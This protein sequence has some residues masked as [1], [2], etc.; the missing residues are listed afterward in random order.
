M[1]FTT[2]TLDHGET[3]SVYM[4]ILTQIQHEIVWKNGGMYQLS[5]TTARQDKIVKVKKVLAKHNLLENMPSSK[6]HRNLD[7]LL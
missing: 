5:G 4:Y 7:S 6:L 1:Y 2:S 3:D